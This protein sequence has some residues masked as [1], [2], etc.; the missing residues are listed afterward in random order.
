M[1]SRNTT[2]TTSSGKRSSRVSNHRYSLSAHSLAST[3]IGQKYQGLS[4]PLP[5]SDN[6]PIAQVENLLLKHAETLCALKNS[7]PNLWAPIDQKATILVRA[8]ATSRLHATTPSLWANYS[9]VHL[10]VQALRLILL[11]YLVAHS[12]KSLTP[13]E[14]QRFM[15]QIQ[16]CVNTAQK[17]MDAV[18]PLTL[19]SLGQTSFRLSA[20]LRNTPL[21]GTLI[22]VQEY[23]LQGC[24]PKASL[25]EEVPTSLKNKVYLPAA[26]PEPQL[27][28]T[29]AGLPAW[30]AAKTGTEQ[31][32]HPAVSQP[33]AAVKKAKAKSTATAPEPTGGPPSNEGGPTGGA[34]PDRVLQL[35]LSQAVQLQVRQVHTLSWAETA[36]VSHMKPLKSF[37]IKGTRCTQEMVPVTEAP[38]LKL[39]VVQPELVGP[40][41]LEQVLK[42][43][44]IEVGPFPT[45]DAQLELWLK[46][47]T[48]FM[49]SA[50]EAR[51]AQTLQG[52]SARELLALP[53]GVRTYVEKLLKSQK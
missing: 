8:V 5:L 6:L 9:A 29:A 26:W 50:L 25:M 30:P 7:N 15:A 11:Q 51:N 12:N 14:D 44:E 48:A 10:W 40:D 45:S 47:M 19:P 18:A 20:L 53:T 28:V 4:L 16:H 17:A 39:Q 33:K 23:V 21:A 38:Y 52:L 42:T 49:N 41:E 43:L 27:E 31:A 36:P 22:T 2:R 35:L 37:G 1:A 3:S 34:T 46:A 13:L 24:P 32:Q